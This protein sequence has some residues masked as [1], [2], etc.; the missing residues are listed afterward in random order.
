MMGPRAATYPS[1]FSISLR[2]GEFCVARF[3]IA[4]VCGSDPIWAIWNHI[5]LRYNPQA[6]TTLVQMMSE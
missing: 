1:P 3:P 2:G 6:N 4:A 5:R